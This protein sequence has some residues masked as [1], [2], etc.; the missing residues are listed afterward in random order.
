MAAA[1]AVIAPDQ[2]PDVITGLTRQNL[3]YRRMMAAC[4]QVADAAVRGADAVELTRVFAQ[5]VRKTVVLLDPEFGLRAHA[6]AGRSASAAPNWNPD[7]ASLARVL[8][9]LA[10]ER[11]PLRVPPIPGSALSHGCLATPVTVGDAVLGYLL[12]LDDTGGAEPDDVDLIVASYAATLFALTLAREQT[13]MELGQRYQGVIV[14][15]LVCGHFL[16]HEDARRKALL[17]GIAESQPYRIAVARICA[18]DAP[19]GSAQ[20]HDDGL[21]EEL[22]S[23][24]ATSV[25]HPAVARG[26]ELVMILPGQRQAPS[27]RDWDAGTTEVLLSAFSQLLHDRSIK[28]QLTCGLSESTRLPELAPRAWR[29]AEHAIDLGTRIGRAGQVISY[30][31]LGIY[32]LLLQI[33]DMHQL[34]Q[35]AG[36]VLG[37]LIEYDAAHKLDLVGTLSVYLSQH[38]S[39]KQTARVLRVHANTVTYRMQRIEQLTPLSLADPDDRLIAH[40]AVKIIESQRAGDRL[41][42][43]PGTRPGTPGASQAAASAESAWKS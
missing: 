25:R 20:F 33:G 26:P 17:L 11:R 28:A 2:Q 14:D 40:V 4:D 27:G 38:G 12:A 3:V 22:V 32:R 37:P 42:S 1:R 18:S 29:Q 41:P 13:S 9:A 39:L 31:E 10:A 7:D 21:E 5:M 19:P 30:D 23:R 35:F 8:R 16:D 43:G 36:D 24:L 6:S 15:S 34:W